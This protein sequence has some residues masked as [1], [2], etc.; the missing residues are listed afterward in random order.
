MLPNYFYEAS[1]SLIPK[2]D[3]PQ[4]NYRSI[5]PKNIYAKILK[6]TLAS[7]IFWHIKIIIH[8]K[9]MEHTLGMQDCSTYKVQSS[10]IYIIN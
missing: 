10:N 8:H 7:W 6:K 2:W 5:S 1:I 3:K 9:Q 4:E